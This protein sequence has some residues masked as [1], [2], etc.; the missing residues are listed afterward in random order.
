MVAV[1]GKAE[2]VCIYGISSMP[3]GEKSIIIE[4]ETK[5]VVQMTEK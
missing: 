2:P 3:P 1:K 5:E 4:C